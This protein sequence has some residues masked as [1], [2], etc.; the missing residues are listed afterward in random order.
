ME[1]RFTDRF[2]TNYVPSDEEI[3]SIKWDLVPRT[4]E[5]A[6]LDEHIRELCAQ[7]DQIQAYVDSHKA[8]I[9]HPRRLPP[10]IVREIFVA[11]LPTSRNAVM[12]AQEAPLLLCR[13]CS[14]WRAIALST[15]RLWASL[16]VS[17]AFLASK[18]PQRLPAVIHWLELSAA[19]PIFLS[20]AVQGWNW[21]GWE[22]SPG[23]ELIQLLAESSARW[24]HL[25]LSDLSKDAAEKFAEMRPPLL[26]SLKFA[27]TISVLR[28]IGSVCMAPRLHTLTFDSQGPE[29]L[30]ELI[31][32]MPLPWSQLTHLTLASIR[33]LERD[34]G[35]LSPSTL[36][37]LLG[38]CPRLISIH[39]AMKE[40]DPEVASLRVVMP[41]LQTFLISQGSLTP[42][43]LE[44][45]FE[46]VSMPQL[47]RFDIPTSLYIWPAN[48]FDTLRTRLPLVEEFT[49][50][51]SSLT[52]RSLP[53]ALQSFPSLMKLVVL[54]TS[55]WAWNADHYPSEFA[56]PA[57]ILDLLTP[58][59]GATTPC[60]R[61]QEL[62]V[63]DCGLVVKSAFDTFIRARMELGQGFRYLR[64]ASQDASIAGL[65]SEGEL[66]FY[67]SRGLEIS[68]VY[69]E[70]WEDWSQTT[71]TPWTGL[72]EE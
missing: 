20:V 42:N 52:A 63:D 40:T 57:Q 55:N 70:P 11:C 56:E 59:P 4:K 72:S 47:R 6:R 51:L 62:F 9:S 1:S 17:W 27:G 7:R 38:R 18:E 30:D 26:E 60:P 16:H 71:P 2:G 28:Q 61:L 67:S 19:C 41:Y 13:I 24:H 23:L 10:D 64:I 39:V 58:H 22:I 48:F 45:L 54:R 8:L 37:T 34:C 25:E 65:L 69:N 50:N 3:E 44:H 53:D 12:S 35:K 66:Q 15:P 49:M 21:D 36:M 46:Y 29:R 43:S 33:E 14:A 32:D 68:L 5:L 31:L